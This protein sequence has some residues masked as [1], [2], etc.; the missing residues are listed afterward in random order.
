MLT[1]AS[2]GVRQAGET[3]GQAGQ[4]GD[5]GIGG[6][7][8]WWIGEMDNG[9]GSDLQRVTRSGMILAGAAEQA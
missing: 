4:L 5:W 3:G 2:K 1:F 7:G 8:D 6:L 9:R